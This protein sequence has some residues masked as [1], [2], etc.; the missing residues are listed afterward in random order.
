M[1][2]KIRTTS[3]WLGV[4]GAIVIVIECVASLFNINIMSGVV[5]DIMLAVCSVLVMLGIINK[6]NV[7]DTEISSENDLLEELKNIE[8]NSEDNNDN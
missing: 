5:G 4:S 8:M 3:F 7:G 1:K 2:E 6:K